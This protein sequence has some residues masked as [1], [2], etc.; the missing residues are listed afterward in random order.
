MSQIVVE[1]R[2]GDGFVMR[3]AEPLHVDGTT[4]LDWLDR[5]AMER[6]DRVFVAQRDGAHG[7]T[8][9]SYAQ[10]LSAAKRLGAVLL[11]RGASPQRPVLVIAA[12]GVAHAEVMLAALYAGVPVSSVSPA[13]AT[14]TDGFTK[15]RSVFDTLQPAVVFAEDAQACSAALDAMCPRYAF[16][17]LESTQVQPSGSQA[18]AAL[19]MARYAISGDTIAK[20]MFTSGSTGAPKGVIHTHAMW[21]A[22]QEQ[23]A[24]AWPFLAEEPPTLLDWLPWSHTFGGNHNVGLVLR[25]GGTLFVD[26]GAATVRGIDRTVHNL[27]DI[28]PTIYFNVPKGYDLLSASLQGDRQARASLFSRLRFL[29]SAAAALPG[30]VAERLREL[31]ASERKAVPLVTGW[32]ATETA[33]AVTATPLDARRDTGIGLPLPG[34]ELKLLPVGELHEIRVRGPNITP[35]Y[36]GRPELRETMF[37]DEGFYRIGDLVRPVD[38]NAPGNGLAFAGRLAEAFKLSTGTWVQVTP[39]RLRALSA[40]A[41]LVQDAVVTGANQDFVGLLLFMHWDRCRAFL[42]DDS[43]SLTNQQVAAH[44]R[45]R[46]HLARAMAEMSLSGGSSTYPARCLIEIAAP[47]PERGEITDKGHLSQVAVLR[48]RSASVDRLHAAER[49]AAVIAWGDS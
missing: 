22:N 21:S 4:L 16:N 32:G 27:R 14:G 35:G 18:E 28:A 48:E 3:N 45:V 38:G 36:W 23:L 49:D 41:P 37:D 42:G 29:K 30:H 2:A 17:V 26:D 39:L 5:W 8:G 33:P 43:A 6:A 1:R 11:E 25:H 20:V 7:W 15:L 10:A 19:L 9:L 13:Y 46:G 40:F 44:P 47:R 31:A 34:I 24:Q 12:N